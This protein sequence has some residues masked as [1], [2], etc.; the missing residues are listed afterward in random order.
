MRRVEAEAADDI[1]ARR[2]SGRQGP[3]A[4]AGVREEVAN[5]VREDRGLRD[6]A[7]DVAGIGR[8]KC[9]GAADERVV[10]VVCEQIQIVG[11]QKEPF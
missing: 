7:D 3:A 2:R 8:R 11:S 5:V 10:G 1:R 9:G 4:T 6:G